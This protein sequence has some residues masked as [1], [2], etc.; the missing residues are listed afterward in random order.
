MNVM[1]TIA[2][3]RVPPEVTADGEA[4]IESITT[5]KPLDPEIARRIHERAEAI[6][7]RVYREQGLVDIAVP[8]IRELRG[9]LP[10]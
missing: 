2:E 5:G 3:N 10:E 8:S 1:K 6:T 4:L 7:Q 9:P